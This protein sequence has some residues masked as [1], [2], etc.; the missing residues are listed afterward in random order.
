MIQLEQNLH[1]LLA[2]PVRQRIVQYLLLH[3][4]ATVQEMAAFY[5]DIPLPTLYRHIKKLAN[6]GVLQ[7]VEKRKIRGTVETTYVL[8]QLN[9]ENAAQADVAALIHSTLMHIAASFTQYFAKPDADPVQD[10]LS[11]GCATFWLSDAEFADFFK[12]I[13][14]IYNDVLAN[15]PRPD[16]KARQITFISAPAELEKGE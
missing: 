4:R 15:T 8:A 5:A 2:H 6:S 16:R 13:G 11:V 12:R 1:L 7:A 3:K 10:M 14:Q 9:M